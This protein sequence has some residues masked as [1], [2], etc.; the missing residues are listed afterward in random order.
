MKTIYYHG[1][2]ADNLESILKHGLSISEEKIWT[3]SEDAIY[4]WGVD[5]LAELEGHKDDSQ[6]QKEYIAFQRAFE[7]GQ[8]ACAKSKDCRVVVLKIELEA[9]EVDVDESCE[10]M[11]EAN[12]IYRD[13]KL[14][15][16]K[17]IVV[18]NDFSLIRG[19]FI[20]FLLDR[21]YNNL[22]FSPIEIQIGNKFKEFGI[23]LGMIDDLVTWE[24]VQL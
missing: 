19:Y 22:E 8:I 7:S 3:C 2:S 23:Y 21:D 17:E 12:C 5:R 24:N 15:E 13:I 20:S 4:L 16:I 14:T 18:S 1:T 11:E 9:D 10:N 6:E